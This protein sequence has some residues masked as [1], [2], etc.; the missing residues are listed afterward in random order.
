MEATFDLF[1]QHGLLAVFG[2]VLIK[3][4]GAPVP[5]LPILLIAGAAA[6]GDRTFAFKALAAATGA[7]MLADLAWFYTGRRFGRR[8][9]TLLCRISISRDSCVRKNESRFM[10]RGAATLVIAKFIPGLDTIAPP[11]AGAAG[12]SLR[13]FALFNG[14]GSLLWAGGGIAGGLVFHSQIRQLLESFS[15]LGRLAVW[16]S[17]SLA[18]L[19]VGWRVWWRRRERQMRDRIPKLQPRDLAAMT[20]AGAAPVILDV[21]AAPGGLPLRGSIASSRH[22]DLAAIE[23]GA[24]TEWPAGTEIVTYCDCPNDASAAKAAALL[25]SRGL[26]ARVLSG[27][28]EAWLAAGYALEPV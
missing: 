21:R 23:A 11:L 10:G 2:W 5:G 20:A 26:D 19:Y 4:L 1:T 15:E 16:A 28:V 27:G 8:I 17:L 14:A 7:S 24:G 25:A 13:S 12:I 22:V 3:Q 9:L 18:T 6:A